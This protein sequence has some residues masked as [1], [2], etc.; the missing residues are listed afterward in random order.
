[1]LNELKKSL[2]AWLE[3]NDNNLF[4]GQTPRSVSKKKEKLRVLR[5]KST[6]LRMIS[7]AFLALGLVQDSYQSEIRHSG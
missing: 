1:M 4:K 2:E 6:F 7:P 3:I 5:V